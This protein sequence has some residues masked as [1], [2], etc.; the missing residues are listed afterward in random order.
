MRLPVLR[1]K[2]DDDDRHD[3]RELPPGGEPC[4]GEPSGLN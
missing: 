1:C 4:P 2:V 3:N